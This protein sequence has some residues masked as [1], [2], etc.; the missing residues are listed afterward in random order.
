MSSY[1]TSWTTKPSLS[2]DWAGEHGREVEL[3]CH[4]K[5]DRITL[6]A[7]TSAKDANTVI[8]LVQ[9]AFALDAGEVELRVRGSGRNQRVNVSVWSKDGTFLG[10]HG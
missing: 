2:W 1:I 5:E 9:L 4:E 3:H 8:A 6:A 10:T 7:M